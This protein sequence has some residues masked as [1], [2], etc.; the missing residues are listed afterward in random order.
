MD[1]K[2]MSEKIISEYYKGNQTMLPAGITNIPD[3]VSWIHNLG[4]RFN[5]KGGGL[6]D[7]NITEN[8]ETKNRTIPD[9][10]LQESLEKYSHMSMGLNP[11]M[12]DNGFSSDFAT[13]HTNNNILFNLRIKSTQ[14]IAN[15]QLTSHYIKLIEN[16]GVLKKILLNTISDNKKD[17]N[18][19]LNRRLG[20][21]TFK[22]LLKVF[23]NNEEGYIEYLLTKFVKGLSVRLPAPKSM[24]NQQMFEEFDKFSSD[25]DNILEILI[26]EEALPAEHVGDNIADSLESIRNIVKKALVRDWLADNG[27]LTKA[28]NLIETNDN[29]KPISPILEEHVDYSHDLSKVLVPFLK[30]LGK[31]GEKNDDKIDNN[32]EEEDDNSGED[33]PDVENDSEEDNSEDTLDDEETITSEPDDGLPSDALS[34]I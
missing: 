22:E 16:D 27:Y 31:L 9:D 18:K 2:S 8:T 17:I 29:G 23:R 11:E 26:T 5:F 7:L 12:V 24:K 25:L 1:A 33:V 10:E 32:E 28:I 34:D 30:K 20:K 3:I 6:P 4:M 19:Y 14:K 15:K 13:V 21:E